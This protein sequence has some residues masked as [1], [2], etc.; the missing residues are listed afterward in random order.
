MRFLFALVAF[1]FAASKLSAED[2]K[3]GQLRRVAESYLAKKP[4]SGLPTGVSFES[5]LEAQDEYIKLL[6]PKLGPVAGY[7]AG[8]V[9][10]AGQKR[11]GIDHPVRGYLLR[12]MLLPDKSTVSKNYGTRPV[13]EPDLVVTVK[14]EGINEATSIQEAARHLEDIVAFIELADAIFATNA[15]VDVGVL[16]AANVGARAGVLGEKR[17]IE[18]TPQFLEAFGKMTLVL[19]D[20]Q[21]KELSR[22]SAEGMMGHPLNPLV[23]FIQDM[24]KHGKRLK[25]GDVISLGSP[26]P[27]VTPPLGPSYKL[28]YEGLPGG[29]LTAT[30]FVH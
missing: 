20:H 14:D 26:S 28:I 7:K 9:T 27:Q 1:A 13:L 22:V 3:P 17:K 4:A 25:A 18:P 23:W 8:V 29:P 30:V 5:A 11:F 6:I 24:K 10:A 12:S 21:G 2:I 16:T 15:T 19:Q